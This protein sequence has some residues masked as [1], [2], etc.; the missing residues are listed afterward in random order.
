VLE[1]VWIWADR[2]LVWRVRGEA[3]RASGW[4]IYSGFERIGGVGGGAGVL[5]GAALS[6]YI[7][8]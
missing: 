1:G 6:I 5:R 4:L 3:W 7:V 2:E 8:Q